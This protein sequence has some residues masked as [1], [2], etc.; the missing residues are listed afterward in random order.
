[1]YISDKEIS[2]HGKAAHNRLNSFYPLFNAL[3]YL[4][5]SGS[6]IHMQFILEFV[7]GCRCVYTLRMH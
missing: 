6:F 7:E 5:L 1:M 2:V 3:V 4:F